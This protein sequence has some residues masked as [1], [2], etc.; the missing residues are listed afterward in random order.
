MLK[1]GLSDDTGWGYE[2]VCRDCGSDGDQWFFSFCLNRPVNSGFVHHCEFCHKCFYFRAGCLM[3]CSHCG[4]GWYNGDDDPYELASL[5]EGMSLEEA[6]H[7][8][9]PNNGYSFGQGLSF[10]YKEEGRGCNVPD[11]ADPMTRSLASEGYWG[12]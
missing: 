7:K 3:G 9:D 8:L 11:C 10:K 4:M 5:A 6:K 1:T 12:F 2:P